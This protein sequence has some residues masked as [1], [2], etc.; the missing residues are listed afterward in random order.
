MT[1][2]QVASLKLSDALLSTG[3]LPYKSSELSVFNEKQL[4]GLE[5]RPYWPVYKA[6][7]PNKVRWKWKRQ[8]KGGGGI[9]PSST[10]SWPGAPASR[11]PLLPTNSWGIGEAAAAS[12]HIKLFI[13]K[14]FP[15]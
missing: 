12:R 2:N 7:H 3:H 6:E 14:Y 8:M 15:K 5:P 1:Q 9:T 13:H 10:L 4:R 11:T